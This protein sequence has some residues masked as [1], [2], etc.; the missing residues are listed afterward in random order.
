MTFLYSKILIFLFLIS[1]SISQ[2]LPIDEPYHPSNIFN[3]YKNN[4]NNELLMLN[5]AINEAKSKNYNLKA[6]YHTS[7]WMVNSLEVIAEQLLIL[8]GQRSQYPI[9]GEYPYGA[10]TKGVIYNNTNNNINNIQYNNNNKRIR[11]KQKNKKSNP[12]GLF[13]SGYKGDIRW[14]K[15]QWASLLEHIG[16]SI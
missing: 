14:S 13:D 7:L 5:K 16:I 12:L 15:K 11:K 3:T 1:I 9:N 8:D 10:N 2:I 4:K 6:F